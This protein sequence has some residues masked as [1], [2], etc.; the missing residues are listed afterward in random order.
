MKLKFRT[1]SF[2]LL[3]EAAVSVILITLLSMYS[4]LCEI[5]VFLVGVYNVDLGKL[6]LIQCLY[7]LFFTFLVVELVM[8][9]ISLIENKYELVKKSAIILPIIFAVLFPLTSLSLLNGAESRNLD[10]NALCTADV[11]DCDDCQTTYS[12]QE[13][14]FGKVA[15][16]YQDVYI[17]D[18]YD[19]S[20][21]SDSTAEYQCI[22]RQS[23]NPR[24]MEKFVRYEDAIADFTLEENEIITDDYNLYY[25]VKD[26]SVGYAM[27][28]ENDTTYYVAMFNTFGEKTIT[29]YSVEDFINDSLETFNIWNQD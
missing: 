18:E 13:N 5:P 25:T 8:F 17:E 23:E 9:F 28:I 1:S 6:F 11:L 24:I 29:E 22:Y 3:I 15:N 19:I 14:K 21:L 20:T 12:Y 4:E 7:I 2:W 26:D 16:L 10:N 27:I